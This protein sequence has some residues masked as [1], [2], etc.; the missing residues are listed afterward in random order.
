MN[1]LL[2]RLRGA[3][4]RDRL[5]KTAIQLI[6]IPSPTRS[7]AAVADRLASLLREDGF[8]VERPVA[9]WPAAPAVCARLPGHTPGRTLQIDGHLDTVHLDFVPPRIDNGTLFGSG[10]SDMKGGIAAAIEAMRAIRQVGLPA[11]AV[12]LTAHELHENPWGNGSQVDNLIA[13]GFVG[14]G[15]LLPEYVADRLPVIGRGLAIVTVRVERDGEPLHEV[16]GG[17][18]QPSVINAGSELIQR[19]ASLDEQ[20]RPLSDPMAGRE[21]LFLGQVHAGEIYNQS[22]TCLTLHG[23]RRWL[24]TTRWQD[25]KTQFLSIVAAAQRELGLRMTGEFAVARDAFQ[26][27][28]SH[29]LVD[30][31][32]GAHQAVTGAT[33]PSGPKPFVDDGNAFSSAAKLPAITH[34]PR[35]TGAH[36]LH[37]MVPIDE[38]ERVALIYALTALSFCTTPP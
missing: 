6:E 29:A 19:L 38:L 28:P 25:A 31:F 2:S 21:S 33:L 12:M 17:L 35:A 10:A 11:G 37:E 8:Q 27:D 36:T 34:G 14:D 1:E 7:A 5:V 26:L 20:L 16:L 22:P 15:V 30:A 3:I 23:T 9:G 13:E 4:Q 24:P 18:E 32:Q